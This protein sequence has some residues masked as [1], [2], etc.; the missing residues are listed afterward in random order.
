LRGRLSP[1]RFATGCL[2]GVVASA[3]AAGIPA[4]SATDHRIRSAAYDRDQVY[5]VTGFYGYATTLLFGEGEA[6]RDVLLGDPEAWD[7][8]ASGNV[9]TVK[10]KAMEPDTSMVVLTSERSY[11]FDVRA[12]PPRKTALGQALDRD[13]SF[14]IRFNYP[15]QE[16]AR[17]RAEAAAAEA[18][19]EAQRQLE[20]ERRVVAHLPDRIPNRKFSFSG[21][22]ELAPVEVWDDGT[23][24]HLRFAKEQPLPAVYTVGP[25]GKEVI[26]P[27]HF[28]RGVLTVQNVAQ[29]LVLRKGALVTCVW[30]EGGEQRTDYDASGSSDRAGARLLR[31]LR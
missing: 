27:K 17:A 7:V 13:Q 3:H 23:F 5:T 16:A 30:N 11:V 18:R 2:C 26:A 28:E 1:R 4:P 15:E 24:M 20:A 6:I 10:P 19:G 21:S 31:P 12:K 29:R 8:R 25:D 9:L 22:A 14:L